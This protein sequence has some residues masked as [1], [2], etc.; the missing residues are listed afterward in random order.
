MWLLQ[1]LWVA[2]LVTK[3]LFTVKLPVTLVS[4]LETSIPFFGSYRPII[5]LQLSETFL[6]ISPLTTHY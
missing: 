5:E 3:M 2:F 4:A 6:L 1:L